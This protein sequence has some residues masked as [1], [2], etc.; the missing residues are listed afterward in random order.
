MKTELINIHSSRSRLCDVYLPTEKQTFYLP[1]C[2]YEKQVL[3]ISSDASPSTSTSDGSVTPLPNSFEKETI[4]TG[5]WSPGC[6]TPAASLFLSLSPGANS[7][8][9][10]TPVWG[11]ESP[12]GPSPASPSP[13]NSSSPPPVPA[14]TQH[15]ILNAK[16]VGIP[17]KV[18]IHGGNFDST[19][20]KDGI[21]VQTVAGDDGISVTYQHAPGKI[22]RIPYDSVVPFRERPK[23]A[24]E[25]GLM[26]VARNNPEHIGKLVRRIHHIYIDDRKD[27]NHRLF[28]VTVDR[29][30]S[31]EKTGFEYLEIHAKDLE[32][33]KETAAERKYS[34]MLLRET[35]EEFS[36]SPVDVKRY[37]LD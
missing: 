8:G 1:E 37:T 6:P 15:W 36:Y 2:D 21:F 20:K 14:P 33:V 29:S 19:K 4:F 9:F 3:S 30:E 24:T 27:E 26:V 22:V 7:P 32:Y 10:V 13:R 16:L 17:I 12:A 35:R 31:K 18:D 11:F 5:A 28:L 23:P 34:T 25:K